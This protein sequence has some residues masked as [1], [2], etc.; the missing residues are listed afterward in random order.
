MMKTKSTKSPATT[1]LENQ[2]R[3]AS[4]I[5]PPGAQGTQ[6]CR[7]RTGKPWFQASPFP[8]TKPLGSQLVGNPVF[9]LKRP[10]APSWFVV[11]DNVHPQLLA[12]L[13]RDT[14]YILRPVDVLG[15]S[16]LGTKHRHAHVETGFPW[17]TPRILGGERRFRGDGRVQLNCVNH[18]APRLV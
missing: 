8:G 9:A 6:Q 16:V 4:A 11:P 7:S 13:M 5:R 10:G 3:Q 17:K 12:I 18:A 15:E 1:P 14:R 2:T